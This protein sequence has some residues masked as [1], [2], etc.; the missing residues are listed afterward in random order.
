MSRAFLLPAVFLLFLLSAHGVQ[1]S[2]LSDTND[3][4]FFPHAIR[5]FFDGT[6]LVSAT[7]SYGY[8]ELAL[9]PIVSVPNPP[10]QLSETLL[11]A[12]V[13]PKNQTMIWATAIT[14]MET[15]VGITF[16]HVENLYVVGE[17][18]RSLDPVDNTI[19]VIKYSPSGQRRY[20]V[21]TA[22]PSN[23]A[24]GDSGFRYKLAR[25][26]R[27]KRAL[28]YLPGGRLLMASESV[29]LTDKGFRILAVLMMKASSGKVLRV[30][31]YPVPKR[32]QPFSME[33]AAFRVTTDKRKNR[34]SAVACFLFYAT[35]KFGGGRTRLYAQCGNLSGKL[36][37][38]TRLIDGSKGSFFSYAQGY[39]AMENEP[40]TTRSPSLFVAYL[41]AR[42]FSSDASE[43]VLSRMD[44]ATMESV[45]WETGGK[46]KR[47]QPL[48]V[49]L[50][51][52]VPPFTGPPITISLW[53]LG[54]SNSVAL[55]LA[56]TVKFRKII[57]KKPGKIIIKG[58]RDA[59]IF[60][61]QYWALY[62]NRKQK[63][64][65]RIHRGDPRTKKPSKFRIVVADMDFSNDEKCTRLFGF[66]TTEVIESGPLYIYRRPNP[67]T[68]KSGKAC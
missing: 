52:P 28:H 56:S 26:G 2:E 62:L 48:V 46:G 36:R 9:H 17:R 60:P 53:H 38:V 64:Q 27:G 47:K 19:T 15:D 23:P 59:F 43:L 39:F 35:V 45:D 4:R 30:I 24:G 37:V 14:T 44:T 41:R 42:N 33:F 63:G 50:P 65:I 51:I 8:D 25:L 22:P 67:I 11:L 49:T 13:H 66:L 31:P 6:V 16:D 40:S 20:E 57:Q 10:S 34:R 58:N 21:S 3:N 12:R 18:H 61:E 55:L 32:A 29:S 1:L 54:K 7:S 5:T 68:S